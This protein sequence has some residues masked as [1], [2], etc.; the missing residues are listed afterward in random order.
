MLISLLLLQFK[1]LHQGQLLLA[2]FQVL[3]AV[4]QDGFGRGQGIPLKLPVQI[5]L[6][7]REQHLVGEFNSSRA[8]R[9]GF[10]FPATVRTF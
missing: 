2:L 6:T 4:P 9:I 3:L 8:V 10:R 5:F 7:E 1:L